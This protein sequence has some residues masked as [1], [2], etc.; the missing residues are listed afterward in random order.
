V[1]RGP[2][3]PSSRG[4]PESRH[5]GRRGRQ[6]YEQLI[7][8][9]IKAVKNGNELTQ[10]TQE[11]FKENMAI[12]DKIG[13]LID[14]IAAAS[15]EQA[16]GVGQ[17]NKAI[18]EMDKVVQQNAATAEESASAS[19][20]LKSEAQKIGGYVKALGGL[21]G[22]KEGTLAVSR[23][24]HLPGA[25]PGRNRQRRNHQSCGLPANSCRG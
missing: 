19:Q 14:E 8:N 16:T 24:A 11:S 9:T 2:A 17:I 20:E 1:K 4:G 22:L 6:E 3:L 12:S 15:Q 5:A 21:I 13:K 18:S 10:A 25:H 7:E 23:E